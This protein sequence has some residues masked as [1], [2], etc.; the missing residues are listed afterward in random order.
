MKISNKQSVV[1]SQLTDEDNHYP[2]SNKDMELTK[3]D[4]QYTVCSIHTQPTATDRYSQSSWRYTTNGYRQ[5]KS[6]HKESEQLADDDKEQ[7][8]NDEDVQ[9]TD[10]DKW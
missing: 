8:V 1:N 2:V 4:T 10:G 7:L 3:K 6:S 5:R 9:L